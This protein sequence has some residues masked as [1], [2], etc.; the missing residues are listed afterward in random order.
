MDK[1][2]STDNPSAWKELSALTTELAESKECEFA[3]VFTLLRNIVNNRKLDATLEETSELL[4]K[5]ITESVIAANT[6]RNGHGGSAD[7]QGN[8]SSREQSRR[9]IQLYVQFV[10]CVNAIK[11]C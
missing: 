3:G 7:W 5:A 10:D 11:Q 6:S 4:K 1:S 8:G 2:V 9:L